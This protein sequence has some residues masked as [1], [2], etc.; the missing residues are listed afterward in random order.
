[1]V[2]TAFVKIHL[3]AAFD[4]VNTSENTCKHF[5][6]PNNV[7][8]ACTQMTATKI[9]HFGATTTKIMPATSNDLHIAYTHTESARNLISNANI[10][11]FWVFGIAARKKSSKTL[12]AHAWR[13]VTYCSSLN[14]NT[15]MMDVVVAYVVCLNIV[16]T[17]GF[18]I[19]CK[20]RIRIFRKTCENQRAR[21]EFVYLFWCETSKKNLVISPVSNVSF[22][23]ERKIHM[24]FGKSV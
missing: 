16:P 1:M 11:D 5:L 8:V 21:I 9:K 3:R 2:G 20:N 14:V 15:K 18:E 22:T 12:N 24:N 19:N 7:R 10:V 4:F 17:V 6:C 13:R 23:G